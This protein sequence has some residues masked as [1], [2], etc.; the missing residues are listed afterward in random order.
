MP[1]V[2][3]TAL[4][5]E[6]EWS[7]VVNAKRIY[8]VL[9]ILRHLTAPHHACDDWAEAVVGLLREMDGQPRWQSSMGC[10]PDWAKHG[11]WS[12]IAARVSAA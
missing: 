6:P 3:P 7:G 10:P 2:P 11:F 1:A 8:C 4:F 9:C 12:Q 5:L